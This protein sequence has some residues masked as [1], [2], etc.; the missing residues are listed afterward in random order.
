MTIHTPPPGL[1]SISETLTEARSH[2]SRLKPSQ[3]LSEL[4]APTTPTSV[5]AL[6]AGIGPAAQR[7]A[8]GSAAISL[9]IERNH[10][11]RFEP[12]CEAPLGV[13]DRHDLRVVMCQEGWI[14]ESFGGEGI[15][16]FWG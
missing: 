9:V 4:Q 13:A 8:E 6:L 11:W 12:Q 2:F 10:E 5:P 3:A 15:A 1:K 14:Y 7:A 16:G